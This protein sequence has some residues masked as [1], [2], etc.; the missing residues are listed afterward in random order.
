MFQYCVDS[1]LHCVFWWVVW[2]YSSLDKIV[3]FSLLSADF[4]SLLWG[5]PKRCFFKRWLS[6]VFLAYWGRGFLGRWVKGLL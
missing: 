2:D 6:A 1:I 3:H 5:V 4:N